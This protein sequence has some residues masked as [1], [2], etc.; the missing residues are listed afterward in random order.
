M[1]DSPQTQGNTR[2][3]ENNTPPVPHAVNSPSSDPIAAE[4][5]SDVIT[6]K[7]LTV[8]KEKNNLESLIMSQND[9]IKG[10]EKEKEKL[11]LS[12]RKFS[13]SNKSM[14]EKLL[15]FDILR[16]MEISEMKKKIEYLMADNKKLIAEKD[17]IY[18][19][20]E[21]DQQNISRV[22]SQV[23]E[24]LMREKRELEER[25]RTTAGT[26]STEDRQN[27]QAGPDREGEGRKV[28]VDLE[29]TNDRLKTA[30]ATIAKL[31]T[32]LSLARSQ[33]AEIELDRDEAR[34]ELYNGRVELEHLNADKAHVEE[35]LQQQVDDYSREIAELK[36]D[37]DELTSAIESRIHVIDELNAKVGRLSGE[38]SHKDS[39]LHEKIP[40]LLEKINSL[41]Q[42]IDMKMEE[43]SLFSK[44][45]FDLNVKISTLNAE[46]IEKDELLID[47]SQDYKKQKDEIEALHGA[48]ELTLKNLLYE[49]DLLKKESEALRVGTAGQFQ[50]LEKERQERKDLENRL[51]DALT[52][53]KK[54]EDDNTAL[55]DAL[56]GNTQQIDA[57]MVDISQLQSSSHQAA[58][59]HANTLA[60]FRDQI[61]SLR[62]EL[63]EKDE[64]L[65]LMASAE[66]QG[67]EKDRTI[68][69]IQRRL[70]ES[71]EKAALSESGQAERFASLQDRISVLTR[72]L[73][74]KTELL[75]A[76][77]AAEQQAPGK[78]R[79]I[80]SLRKEIDRYQERLEGATAEHAANL[81]ALREKIA[82]LNQQLLEKNELLTVM[83][84]ERERENNEF[85]YQTDL[86]RK[87]RMR[88]EGGMNAV[89]EQGLEQGRQLAEQAALLDESQK[90]RTSLEEDLAGAAEKINELVLE[91]DRLTSLISRKEQALSEAKAEIDLL[92]ANADTLMILQAELEKKLTEKHELS[93]PATA[94]KGELQRTALEYQETFEHLKQEI[95]MLNRNLAEKEQAIKLLISEKDGLARDVSAQREKLDQALSL[96]HALEAELSESRRDNRRLSAEHNDIVTAV[97]DQQGEIRALSRAKEEEIRGLKAD[98]AAYGSTVADLR[99]KLEQGLNEN[100]D[101]RS[102]LQASQGTV[103]E[104][105]SPLFQ[106][107]EE[108]LPARVKKTARTSRSPLGYVLLLLFVLGGIGAAFYAYTIGRITLPMQKPAAREELKKELAYNDMFALLTKASASD[109]VKFQAT[110]LTESL[111]LKSDVPGDKALFDFQNHLYFKINISAPR[112]GLGEKIADDP[113]SAIALTAGA[114]TVTPLPHV[115]VKEI[116]TFYRK[117]EPVSVMFY[118]AFPKTVLTS[119]STA[120]SLSFRDEKGRA[121][122]AW[123]MKTLRA[124]NL[125]P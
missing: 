99:M 66:A 62:Q 117:E 28:S 3:G 104:A 18:R 7:F 108:T 98:L 124:N 80:E 72:E 4:K 114:G 107:R 56:T 33:I 60:V 81:A 1:T 91:Q 9:I 30:A 15:D 105:P 69:E 97:A 78:D 82:L 27:T 86:L 44:E 24:S 39:E 25:L 19:N 61:S 21:R 75:A 67:A 35:N 40:A 79:D 111:V 64:Q 57:L 87:E 102:K 46:M 38:L 14:K 109:T 88:L 121:D 22:D 74:E 8:A 70:K 43:N 5:K 77:Y 6:E 123:D 96:T 17:S 52:L 36:N 29:E 49:R 93:G 120:L 90:Q 11:T 103:R 10:L 85:L 110:L 42:S 20:L 23:V 55:R 53:N 26:G 101:L 12:L 34:A 51:L 100:A 41:S 115:H 16:N 71:E 63:L 47:I 58:E 68:E 113:Y 83:T 2:P 13:A 118:S 50:K 122:I 119:G 45:L 84:S 116:K 37:I 112:Q 89:M 32:E 94:E 95:I 54:F 59:E 31:E 48:H 106:G 65:T 76:M 73:S 92:Q 125:L